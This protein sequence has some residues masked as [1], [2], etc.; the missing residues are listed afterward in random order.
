MAEM[1]SDC[2][3]G[4]PFIFRFQG[5]SSKNEL[6]ISYSESVEEKI[7]RFYFGIPLELVLNKIPKVVNIYFRYCLTVVVFILK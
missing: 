1:L 5:A 7:F 6:L 2:L 3:K 4:R